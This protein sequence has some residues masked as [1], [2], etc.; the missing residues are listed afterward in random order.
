MYRVFFGGRDR[1]V[2]GFT[3]TYAISA[4]HHWCCE[5]ESRLGQSVQHYV[6]KIVS[7]LQQ[8]GGF[9]WFLWF[10]PQYNWNIV[11]NGVKH[12]QTNSIFQNNVCS[13]DR[14]TKTM[15]MDFI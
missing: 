9:L 4:Y 2:V 1:M 10:P 12:H 11:E 7:E 5:F 13:Y 14:K 6:I 3:T 8:V 15:L